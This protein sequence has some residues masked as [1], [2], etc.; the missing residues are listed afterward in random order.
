LLS[1][2]ITGQPTCI[3]NTGMHGWINNITFMKNCEPQPTSDLLA[4]KNPTCD[5]QT[6]AGGI[7]CCRH[8]M[9]LLD[10]DQ[11]DDPRYEEVYLK[12]RFYYQ[13]FTQQPTRSH[14]N[15]RRFYFQT[16]AWASEYD[17]V[18]CA[19]G[20]PPSDC[21]YIITS[22]IKVSQM[23]TDCENDRDLICPVNHTQ[24]SLIYAGGHCHAPSC[25]SLELYN[26]DTGQLICRQLPIIG[27]GGKFNEL[28]YLHI[29]PCLWGEEEGL[30]QP[31]VLSKNT[32]LL[33][34]KK[35]NS[36]YAHYGE[37]A[38][39]QMRGIIL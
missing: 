33:S 22:R 35:N 20:T 5:I 18:P 37:M 8:Q 19:P 24:I 36:T 6:Y 23:I 11:I 17:V 26:A 15:L 25:I 39:W 7:D 3:C 30:L 12:F 9:I 32:N 10:A 14:K 1:L 16:E 13:E 21:I 27:T 2:G 38:S 4:L 31:P 28:D 29:P 34:I